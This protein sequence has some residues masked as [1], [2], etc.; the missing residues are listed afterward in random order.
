MPDY[1][2]FRTSRRISVPRTERPS[3]S[4]LKTLVSPIPGFPENRRREGFVTALS[5]APPRARRHGTYLL[6]ELEGGGWLASHFGRAD[7]VKPPCRVLRRN[8]I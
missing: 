2:N 4:E 6:V 8:F 7:G 3:A 1:P 5:G